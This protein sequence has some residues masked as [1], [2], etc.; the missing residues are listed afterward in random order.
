MNQVIGWEGCR[1]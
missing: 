1:F